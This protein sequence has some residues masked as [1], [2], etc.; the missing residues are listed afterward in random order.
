LKLQRVALLGYQRKYKEALTLLDSIPDTP[1]NFGSA[2]GAGPK[3][4][5]QAELYR[6]MG[7]TA[8]ARPLYAQTLPHIRVQIAQLHGANQAFEWNELASVELGLGH[9]TQAL[10]AIAKSLTIIDGIHDS[11][12][13][14]ESREADA[15]LYAEAHRPDLA[16]PLLD[17]IFAG[18]GVGVYYAPVMLWLDPAWDPIRHDPGFQALLE[19]YARY[20]PAAVH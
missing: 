10:D 9:T 14:P 20:K 11:V 2:G 16:V 8:R 3:A 6:Q 13:G 1:D 12:Y 7:D 4:A 5:W 17:K 18:P 15:Q 19:K